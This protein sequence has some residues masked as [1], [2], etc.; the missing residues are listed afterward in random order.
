MFEELIKKPIINQTP[1]SYPDMDM[2]KMKKKYNVNEIVRLNYNE[3]PLG[4]SPKAAKAM[5]NNIINNNFYP[6]FDGITLRK[7]L[8]VFYNNKYNMNFDEEN[9]IIGY[10]ASGLLSLIG[11]VFLC[12]GDE[13]VTSQL[14]FESYEI[15]ANRN[16]ANYVQVPT[17]ENLQIN[18]DG[19]LESI[20]KKTKMIIICNPNNP[21]GMIL[22]EEEIKDFIMK[23]PE[24][25]IIV[26][27]EAYFEF[28]DIPNYKSMMQMIG[29]YPNVIVIRTFSKVYGLAGARVGYAIMNKEISVN[30]IKGVEFASSLSAL[31]GAI[32][33]LN[34]VEFIKKAKE[35]IKEGREY[36]SKEFKKLGFKVFP[37]Q[38]NFIYVDTKLDTKFIAEKLKEKG[39]LIRGDLPL[40]RITVGTMK[41]N[42]RLVS[43]IKDII[44]NEVL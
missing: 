19:I 13:L 39:I 32:A 18:L 10:G 14:T 17:K 11:E 31:E 6:E 23:V 28:I 22:K 7:N 8:A 5:M 25:V 3:N 26:V 36:L 43:A 20:T 37:T 2:E 21:T 15:S 24:N 12:Y 42:K 44:S 16:G 9:F 30:L 33:A 29:N 35:V 27:D 41:Q 4:V 38:T 34:D 40:S 1:I